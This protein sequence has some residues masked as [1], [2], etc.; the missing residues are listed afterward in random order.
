MRNI[1]RLLATTALTAIALGGA[2]TAS[3]AD[4]HPDSRMR[5]SPKMPKAGAHVVISVRSGCEDRRMTA[6]SFGLDHEVTLHRQGHR[7]FAGSGRVKDDAKPGRTYWVRAHCR[8]S[9]DAVVGHFTVGH[10]AWRGS[11]AG[12]GGSAGGGNAGMTVAGTGLVALAAGGSV[13]AL[14]RRD[15]TA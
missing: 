8:S 14:R 3:Q 6:K 12:E 2:A 4:G 13:L 10:R 11:H 5:I 9:G 7:S 1:S 15:D